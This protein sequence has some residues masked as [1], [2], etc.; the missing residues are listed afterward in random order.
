MMAEGV[1]LL[2]NTIIFD[3]KPIAVPYN[4]RISYKI[5]QLL[6]ILH[7]CCVRGG[8]SLIKLHMISTAL[9][10]T[11]SMHKLEDF[12]NGCLTALPVIRFDPAVNR[13]LLYAL[14]C[15]LVQQQKNGKIKLTP[16]G[17]TYIN[18]V[19]KDVDLLLREKNFLYKISTKV[20]EG[21]IQNIILNWGDKDAK[22]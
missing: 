6:L 1:Y 16:L 11:S 2:S 20:T 12:A 14:S 18:L 9:N 13:A 15:N 22:N 17:K 7:L 5:S 3:S 4:Y 21:L 10:S 19:M 8:C